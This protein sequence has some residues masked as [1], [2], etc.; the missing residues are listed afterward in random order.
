MEQNVIQINSGITT[1]VTVK[2]II[3][4]KT[5]YVWSSNTCICENGKYL[6]NI[7]DDSVVICVEVTGRKKTIP[8]NCNE[9]N[10]TCEAQISIFYLSIY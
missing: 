9:K 2:N 1:N 10:I 8:T 4:V 7:M 3:Y 6:D 5:D